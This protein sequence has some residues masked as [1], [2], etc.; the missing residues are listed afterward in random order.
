[1]PFE[2]RLDKV[3]KYRKR[4]VE[5]HTRQVAEASRIVVDIVG[6]MEGLTRDI[7]RLLEDNPREIQTALDVETLIFRGRWLTHLEDRLA[8]LDNE[9]AK[10]KTELSNQRSLLTNAWQDQEVLVRLRDKQKNIWL[11]D[12][13]KR[14]IKELDEIGQIRADRSQR[15]KVSSI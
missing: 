9:L 14:E 1:M 3:L 11:Q 13:H 5:K 10:A 4:V 7:G 8:E 15:E 6:K 12:Q 2:F